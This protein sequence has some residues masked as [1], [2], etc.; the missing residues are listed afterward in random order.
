[1]PDD[2][3]SITDFEDLF[4]FDV[5]NRHELLAVFFDDETHASRTMVWGV[6]RRHLDDCVVVD[7]RYD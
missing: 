4:S 5:V 7:V 2:F 6:A 1:M 3:L